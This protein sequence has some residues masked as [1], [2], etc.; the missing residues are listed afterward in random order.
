MATKDFSSK[1]IRVS[2]LLASGGIAGTSVGMAIYSASNA[3]NLE[4]GISDSV[5]FN[6]VGSDVF[7]F[8]SGSANVVNNNRTNVT[9]FGGDVVVSGTLYA[10]RQI[11]E[12]DETVTGSLLISGSMIVSQSATIK[13]GL[14]VNS[15]KEGGVENDFSVFNSSGRVAIKVDASADIVSFGAN[16]AGD[17]YV[18]MSP[19]NGVLVNPDPGDVD[20]RVSTNGLES[21]I[22]VDANDDQILV[23]SNQTT[24]AAESLGTDTNFFVSG[25]IG[26]KD[27][28]TKGTAVFGGDVV[29]SGTLYPG[30]NTD[31]FISADGTSLTIDS[32]D[33]II[34][35]NDSSFQV[36]FGSSGT[37][38]V[39]AAYFNDGTEGRGTVINTNGLSYLDFRVE[40]D[41]KLGSILVD[42]GTEQVAMLVNAK[43]A[44][45]A[46]DGAP[47]PSDIALYVSG[48][49][50]GKGTE[51]TSVFGL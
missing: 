30:G 34:L 50:N 47:I 12:V 7:L 10:E 11:I 27:S 9:L 1:Q 35:E 3:S 38:P 19:A 48:A 24:A 49:I 23:G 31:Q 28:A 5:I 14:T 29:I 20:F 39:L 4:G 44:S 16:T 43:D 41:N 51:G 46:Y 13:E 32:N 37:K 18:E 33:N 2:Q 45:T 25:S 15:S 26:S 21:A 6:N 8:V 40:S 36:R 22:L 17:G 42:G